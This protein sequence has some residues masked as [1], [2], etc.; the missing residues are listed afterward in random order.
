MDGR[1]I[2]KSNFEHIQQG[3]A[4][5]LAVLAVLGGTVTSAAAASFSWSSLVT[6]P[7]SRDEARIRVVTG[8]TADGRIAVNATVDL[9]GHDYDNDYM[10]DPW[11]Q[12]G[13]QRQ[14]LFRG[15]IGGQGA[16]QKVPYTTV[17]YFDQ[18]PGDASLLVG[19]QNYFDATWPNDT[20]K[21]PES[22]AAGVIT[23]GDATPY[24]ESD[25]AVNL[26]YTWNSL[27]AG[28]NFRDEVSIHLR[29]LD[30]A[31]GRLAV[32]ASINLADG[33]TDDD[34]IIEPWVQLGS[35]RR[36]LFDG[37]VGGRLATRQVP[38]STVVYFDLPSVPT[39][40]RVGY[41]DYHDRSWP[42]LT[43][44][45]PE[46][47]IAGTID[48]TGA[49]AGASDGFPDADGDGI[50]DGDDNCTTAANPSQLNTDK[51]ALGDACDSDDDNDGVA[52]GRDAF[53]LNPAESADSD[54]D[55]IGDNAD[56]TPNGADPVIGGGAGAILHGTE[57]TWS[58]LDTAPNTRD[59]AVVSVKLAPGSDGRL[60]VTARVDL[61]GGASDDDYI[62]DPWI[63][64]GNDRRVLNGTV[65]GYLATHKVPYSTV[66][67]FN[68]PPTDA[69]LRVGYG[70]YF[71]RSWPGVTNRGPESALLGIVKAVSDG[72]AGSTGGNTSGQA[73]LIDDPYGLPQP[74]LAEDGTAIL[75]AQQWHDQRRPEVLQLFATQ[76]YGK[77]PAASIATRY[78]TIETD[79]NAL[80]GIAT[81]KQ[82]RVH[83]SNELGTASL[84]LLLYLP[85]LVNGPSPVFLGLNYHG[86]H[87]IHPDPAILL[88]QSPVDT[89]DGKPSEQDRGK[90]A[91]R[92]PVEALLARGYGLATVYYGDL[93]PDSTDGLSQSVIPLFFTDG[94][95]APAA[96]QWGAIGAW[97]WGLSRAMDYLRSDTDIDGDRVAVMGFSRLGKTA[98]WAGAQ[99]PRFAMVISN[100]SGTLGA[101][102]SRRVGI[103]IGKESVGRITSKYGYWFADNAKQYANNV[104]LLPV[105]QHQL[106]A[107]IAPR[108]VYI[109][110]AANDAHADPQGE[111]E[112][113]LYAS[114][115]YQLLGKTGIGAAV[116]PPPNTPVSGGIGY[117]VRDGD[118]EI[119]LY[120][121]Q[122]FLDFAD[123][124]MTKN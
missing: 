68:A 5:S 111:F 40:L 110:S 122:R 59:E 94:Q 96:D 123:Q 54:G 79:N 92:W 43:N 91:W 73:M 32:N 44:K 83:F 47:A 75:S 18:P 120:D 102:L 60:A 51:D 121:W 56:A 48:A 104:S 112:S 23:T 57:Y 37:T 50:A 24:G 116:M 109:A 86:N 35:Q 67:Y 80:G 58:A 87:S 33:P 66:L 2:I 52:D 77:T 19:Y 82:V 21:G 101:S 46:S 41:Q 85:K 90:R 34:Y 15:R 7:N 31:D 9:D 28:P 55:G 89:A 63:Q 11:V 38:Y 64:L 98:L 13:T 106:I 97:A 72:D 103:A 25:G 95:K 69:E 49:S 119:K 74:L 78:T 29:A 1:G 20:G 117:H 113:G 61:A 8:N 26:E 115:V 42:H 71:D 22:F 12:V 118:H 93:Y 124:H 10:V 107:L 99:D 17:V 81:R 76:I 3:V 39:E 53:P 36:L 105:D 70:N 108:P 88:P 62:T 84:D 100:A 27:Q 4:N 45:G 16:E 6:G 114:V 30:T 65:G 14:L